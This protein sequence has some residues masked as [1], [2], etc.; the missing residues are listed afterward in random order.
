LE[1]PAGNQTAEIQA[2]FPGS[3]AKIEVSIQDGIGHSRRRHKIILTAMLVGAA[4]LYYAVLSPNRFGAFHD[5][6]IYVTTAKSIAEG[7]GYRIISLPYEPAQTKYPP[8]YPLLLSLVWKIDPRFPNN[9]VWMMSLSAVASLAFIALTYS[10]LTR[11]GYASQWLALGV[12]SLTAL[13][14]R[15]TILATS[16]ASE[17]VFSLL[18]I[19]GLYVAEKCERKQKD[20]RGSVIVGLAIGMAFLTRGAGISLLMAVGLYSMLKGKRDRRWLTLTIGSAIV[21][22][23]FLW[24]QINRATAEG[25]NVAYYTSYFGDIREALADV[26]AQTG[27]SPITTLLGIVG[28]NG[29]GLVVLSAP[30]L[31]SGLNGFAMSRFSESVALVTMVLLV[32]FIFVLVSSGFLRHW[33]NRFGLLHIYVISY[34]LLFLVWPYNTYDRFL[35]PLLPFLLLFGATEL[36]RAGWLLRRE[37]SIRSTVARTVGALVFGG[38]CTLV[39]GICL[40]NYGAGLYWSLASASLKKTCRPAVQDA[41]AIE[42]VNRNT[43]QSDILV[44]LR[45]PLY[46]LYTGRK[47]TL[48]FKEDSSIE[49]QKSAEERVKAA[50][51]IIEDSRCRYLI[52]NWANASQPGQTDSYAQGYKILID[53]NPQQFERVFES[54]DCRTVIYRVVS[55]GA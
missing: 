45:D 15:T 19:S 26:R 20:Q 7:R 55:A 11:F 2:R 43:D 46:Y 36:A 51:R 38:L 54:S 10:Y 34:C 3:V 30:M 32:L 44:C 33:R 52:L 16:T 9:L 49:D 23:W 22:G 27:A 42:W 24:C 6:S 13:N 18:C 29:L 25:A 14:L 37:L 5:D 17:M 39:V 35:V 31:C 28:R 1:V 8:L 12:V 47:A 48:A 41:Q 4:S 40:F 50:R 53:N 21:L